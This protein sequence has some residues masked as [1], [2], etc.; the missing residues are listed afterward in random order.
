MLTLRAAPT[1]QHVSHLP[2]VR[3]HELTGDR[4]GT[5]A[6]DLKHP[7][8]LIFAPNHDPI[9]RQEDGGID[10]EKITAIIILEVEDY[11]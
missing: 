8:R 2:P 3:R 7:Y 4:S 5:F 6:V 10:L 11:H 9:P 1:L